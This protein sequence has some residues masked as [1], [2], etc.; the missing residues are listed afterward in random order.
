[1]ANITKP[2]QY[3]PRWQIVQILIRLLFAQTSVSTVK[4]RKI[5]INIYVN[6]YCRV[7]DTSVLQHVADHLH[8]AADC[9]PAYGG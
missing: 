8:D 3:A 6:I 5:V 2:D 9:L 1:M 4:I 7:Q